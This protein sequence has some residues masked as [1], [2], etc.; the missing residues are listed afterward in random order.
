MLRVGVEHEVTA[1]IDHRP[2]RG[3]LTRR[4]SR[5]IGRRLGRGGRGLR[6]RGRV[7]PL[8]AA[9]MARGSWSGRVM[10]V[11]L[12]GS[13]L[14]LGGVSRLRRR[15]RARS[16]GGGRWAGPGRTVRRRIPAVHHRRSLGGIARRV[17]GGGVLRPGRS[18]S[19]RGRT[20]RRAGSGMIRCRIGAVP[21]LPGRAMVGGVGALPVR[22]PVRGCR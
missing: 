19:L 11:V 16:V 6:R 22:C 4:R 20:G 2:R 12:R 15:H 9:R 21:G 7:R 14:A 18:L 13:G 10:R 1:R 8:V 3:G 5:V 17:I